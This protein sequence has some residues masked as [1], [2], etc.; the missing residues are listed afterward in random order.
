MALTLGGGHK[1]G[2]ANVW[3]ETKGELYDAVEYHDVYPY[4]WP[5][6]GETAG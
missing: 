4:T 3:D 5:R 1:P 6:I 2:R